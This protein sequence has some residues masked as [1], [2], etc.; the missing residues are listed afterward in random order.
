MVKK[1]K[2][3]VITILLLLSPI[4]MKAQAPPHPN[5]G[6]A[7]TPGTNTPVGAGAPIA[8][9]T[10]ILLAFGMAYAIKKWQE[11]NSVKTNNHV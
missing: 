6:G 9:G 3:T 4:L 7:P 2:L 11:L 10:Y 5:N 8:D 1:I